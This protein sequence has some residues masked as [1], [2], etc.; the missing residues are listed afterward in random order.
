MKAVNKYVPYYYCCSKCGSS[1]VCTV[2]NKAANA[3]TVAVQGNK[4]IKS[5]IKPLKFGGTLL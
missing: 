2:V 5:Y 3:P 4:K 1:F